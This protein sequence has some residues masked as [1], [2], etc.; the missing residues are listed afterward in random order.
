M[1]S[2]LTDTIKELHQRNAYMYQKDLVVS[3]LG[4]FMN[5]S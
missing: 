5:S 2:I 1:A 4:S 3:G